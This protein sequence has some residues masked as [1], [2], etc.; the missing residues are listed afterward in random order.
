[1]T[2]EELLATVCPPI[3]R[4]GA[5]WYFDPETTAAGERLGLDPGTFYF[6]GRGGVLGDVPWTVV[7]AA[8][9]YFNPTVVERAWTAGRERVAPAEAARAHLGCAEAF[10]RRHFAELA[11]LDV[12][13]EA[14]EAVVQA[15]TRD[16]SA[17][18]LFAGQ[19]AQPL[20]EDL[21]GRAIRLVVTLRELRGSAHLVAVV[22][23][24]LATPVAH[25]A[26]RPDALRLF[27]WQE[28]EVPEPTDAD[29]AALQTAEALTDRLLGPAFGVLDDSGREALASGV[30]AMTQ[31]LPTA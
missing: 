5:A 11:G 7:H 17:L 26:A 16:F 8:F 14:A 24:G 28:A 23:S 15:A 25:R 9:G 19:V 3:N 1:M 4:L 29:R 21:P 12:F 2:I 27:G 18:P 13:C 22:A 30:T 20:P 10:G 31:A 6:L